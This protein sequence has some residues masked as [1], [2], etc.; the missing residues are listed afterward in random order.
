MSSRSVSHRLT[1]ALAQQM[2]RLEEFILDDVLLID[3]L[4]MDELDSVD[5]AIGLEEMWPGRPW[6]D[7][8]DLDKLRQLRTFGALVAYV[9]DELGSDAPPHKE[10]AR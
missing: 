7:E 1:T 3:D 6:T 5:F 10:S 8:V 9:E 2:A 4:G